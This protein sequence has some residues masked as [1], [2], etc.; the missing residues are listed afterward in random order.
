MPNTLKTILLAALKTT[1][2]Q[3]GKEYLYERCVDN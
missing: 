2:P 3:L 1:T